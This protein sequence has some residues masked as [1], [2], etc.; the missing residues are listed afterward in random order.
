MANNKKDVFSDLSLSGMSKYSERNAEA[1]RIKR[2]AEMDERIRAFAAREKNAKWI[3]EAE[4]FCRG[5][6]LANK[7]ILDISKEA[8]RLPLI[9]EEA[10][11]LAKLAEEERLDK[12]RAESRAKQAKM[13]ADAEEKA[14]REKLA[15]E[16]RE[17]INLGK[18]QE[19]DK[20]IKALSSSARSDHWCDEVEKADAD[21]KTLATDVKLLVKGMGDLVKM[22]AESKKIKEDKSAAEKKK[23]ADAAREKA[24]REAALAKIEND[25]RVAKAKADAEEAR[26][27]AERE[28]Q[29]AR[30][31]AA[32]EAETLRIE[33]EKRVAKAKAD[34]EEARIKA[35]REA[36]AARE[37]AAADARA[38]E[39]AR[40]R[41]EAADRERLA[42]IAQDAKEKELRSRLEREAADR[43][44]KESAA[45]MED[46]IAKLSDA[47]RTKLWISEVKKAYAAAEAMSTDAKLMVAELDTLEEMFAEANGRAKAKELD[48]KINALYHTAESAEWA[49]SVSE[50]KGL[51]DGRTG[52]RD[53]AC[54]AAKPYM[55]KKQLL[56][57]MYLKTG[58]ILDEHKK[59]VAENKAK[60]ESE[61]KRAEAKRRR[62]ETAEKIGAGVLSGLKITL[63]ILAI[64]LT[65]GA[66]VALS[67]V[68]DGYLMWIIP[69]TALLAFMLLTHI[70]KK[71][72]K[73]ILP[74]DVLA[75]IGGIVLMLVSE[76]GA[77][78]PIA[79][80]LFA[81]LFVN[82]AI[83]LAELCKSV[84][85]LQDSGAYKHSL[86]KLSVDKTIKLALMGIGG[87]FASAALAH[88]IGGELFWIP[89][90]IGLA[91]TSFSFAFLSRL[92]D[93]KCKAQTYGV[94]IIGLGSG[95]F[96][97]MGE[98]PYVFAGL[99]FAAGYFIAQAITVSAGLANG[100]KFS[101]IFKKLDGFEGCG[102]AIIAGITL[103]A[104]LLFFFYVGYT[105]FIISKDGVLEKCY[106]REETLVIP[107]G[108][109]EI[110]PDALN[111]FLH[112]CNAKVGY[113]RTLVIPEGVEKI[114]A[115]AF[116]WNFGVKD[117]Y[118]PAS[119][120]TIDG[121]L[122]RGSIFTEITVHYA[123]SEQAAEQFDDNITVIEDRNLLEQIFVDSGAPANCKE[124]IWDTD[125][126]YMDEFYGE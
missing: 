10:R 34:A 22:V 45:D 113:V 77:L 80:V 73:L 28:A 29:A 114:G 108:V 101:N 55:K 52:V 47:P 122:F 70:F 110:A 93:L 90:G 19:F 100:K 79:I 20:R 5:E 97:F 78:L 61:K 74:V 53:E 123:G 14:F 32:R 38:A 37:K 95:V 85:K 43:R 86:A 88:Y 16:E 67:M 109:T 125:C 65:V 99:M 27:K 107:E 71:T 83:S 26:I 6:E 57:E 56:E 25:K 64:L 60:R 82:G 115:N 1:Q 87:V 68:F 72:A 50:I 40:L 104:T 3:D 81:Y 12:I 15:R 58:P 89:M 76:E 21:A 24:E 84:R 91:I 31:R 75:A 117:L 105:D 124:V 46:L 66:G 23:A 4:E 18:A 119:L 48:D 11:G 39:E 49:E 112:N 30:E 121:T 13:E 62:R 59:R 102:S 42:K 69:A 9:R 111:M 63:G 44:D 41:R 98:R 2:A 92:D 17:R 54:V 106:S 116:F 51:L 118:L 94:V 35:E 96:S 8:Y 120:E 33:N 7:D 103:L 126:E 36:E